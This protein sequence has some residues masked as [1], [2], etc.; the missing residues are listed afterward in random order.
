MCG[1]LGG[2]KG[3][4]FS[5]GREKLRKRWMILETS[6]LVLP[7][8]I[9]LS[10]SSTLKSRGRM[11]PLEP[12]Y[13]HPCPHHPTPQAPQELVATS[14]GVLREMKSLIDLPGGQT[15]SPL[16]GGGGPEA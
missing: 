15:V 9:S 8:E 7:R 14:R 13:T 3:V 12:S 4:A 6:F 16:R 5:K 11:V 1:C 10:Q 2:R